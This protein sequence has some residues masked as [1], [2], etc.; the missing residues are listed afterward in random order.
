MRRERCERL[1]RGSG[2]CARDLKITHLTAHD[3]SAN[4]IE[5]QGATS[6][7]TGLAHLTELHFLSLRCTF[8]S[9]VYLN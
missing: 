7:S 1:I 9:F 8:L 4:N 5:P 6:L 3:R 2:E